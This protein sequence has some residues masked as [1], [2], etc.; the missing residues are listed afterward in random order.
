MLERLSHPW[1]LTQNFKISVRLFFW[2]HSV[3]ARV[4]KNLCSLRWGWPKQN[5]SKVLT[6][7]SVL[8]HFIFCDMKVFCPK[9]NNYFTISDLRSDKAAYFDENLILVF[10]VKKSSTFHLIIPLVF[11]RTVNN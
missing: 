3:S 9:M 1:N 11:P 4:I 5:R 2:M 10:L 7:S 6:S 8:F